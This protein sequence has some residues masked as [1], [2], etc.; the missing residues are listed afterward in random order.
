MFSPSRST[1]GPA[2][3]TR[4]RRRQRPLSS[5][6]ATQQPKVK[7]Q[8]VPLTEQTFADPEPQQQTQQPD[9]Q[10]GQ[11]QEQR[12]QQRRHHAHS[13]SIEVKADKSFGYDQRRNNNDAENLQQQQ[14]T[15]RRDL[16]V[17]A[18]K[19]KH[20]DRAANKGD[21]SLVLTSTDAYTVSKLPALP[22]RIR[23]D[24]S[25]DQHGQISS[26]FGYA[27][28]LT[29]T[30]AIVWP[31]TS[32]SPSPETFTFT[33]PPTSKP[34]DPLPVGCLVSPSAASTEPG[35]V[36]VMAATGRVVYWES[37]SSAAT[38]AFIKK[39]R[40]GVEYAV[41]GMTSGERVV[42][43]TS[44]ESAGFVLTFNT[45]RLAYLNVR[46]NHGR[47]AVSAQFL[48]SGLPTTTSFLGS[49]R[50]AFSHLS[51]R[52]DI[53]AVRA[54]RAAR[55]GEK[56]IVALGSKGR[57]QA[58]KIHRGGHNESLGEFDM[59]DEIVSALREADPKSHDFTGD[60]FEALDFTFVPKGLEAKY[61]ELSRLSQA[62]AIDDPALQHLVALVSLTRK[63]TSRYA[64]VEVILSPDGC[65][66]G[67]IRPI[68]SY[69]TPTTRS[70]V[71]QTM[72]P[73][74]YLP[75]PALVAF[76]IFDRA[77]VV[78]SVAVPPESPDSQL[79][80]DNHMVPSSFEDVV[81][82]R[83]DQ[84]HEILGSGFEETP[85]VSAD[86]RSRRQK[87]QNPAAVLLVRGAGVIRLVTSDIDKFAS[88]QAPSVTAKSKLE[89]AVFFGAKQD[90]PLIFGRRQEI[91]FPSEEVGRAALE[92][93]H[94]ILSSTTHYLSTLPAHLEDNLRARSQALSRLV[95]HLR[96]T[97]AKLNRATRWELLFNAEKMHVATLLWKRHET[98][99][100]S[101]STDDKKSLVG[102]IVE[103]IHDDQKHKPSARVGQVDPVRHWF[104]ND[105][106]RLDIF[107]AWAYEVIKVLY[108]DRLLDDAKVTVM[109]QEAMQIATCTH[110]AAMEFR[111]G[112]LLAYGLDG[113][114]LRNGVIVRG[115]EGLPEPWTAT[116]YVANN[117]RRLVDL[118]QQW[119]DSHF[120]SRGQEARTPTMPDP[121]ILEK[122][123]QDLPALTDG[124]LTSLLEHARY[125]RTATTAEER[126]MAHEFAKA[127]QLDRYERPRYLARI[128]HWEQAAAMAKKHG[129][130]DGLAAILL[131]HTDKLEADIAQPGATPA[132][133]RSATAKREAKKQQIEDD[134]AEFGEEFA[135]PLY[136][137]L[138]EKIGVGAVLEFEL[139][140]LGY[141]TKYLRSRPELAKISWINDVEVERDVGR[142]ADTLLGL[143]LSKEQQVW[144]RKVELSLGKLALLAE[145]EEQTADPATAATA[146]LLRIKPDEV[147]R[148]QSLARADKELTAI[149]IQEQLHGHVVSSTYGAVDDG[150]ALN[151]AMDTHST[152]IPRRQKA[153]YQIFEDGMRRLLAHEALDALT[154]IDLLT[155]VH[156]RP[157]DAPKNNGNHSNNGAG[158]I[159]GTVTGGLVADPF[160]LALCVAEACCKPQEL[161]EVKR[162]IWRRLLIRDDWPRINDTQLKDDT[163]VSLR[164]ADTT[165]FAAL[166][167]CI[168][169]EDPREPFRPMPPNEA[170]GAFTDALDRRFGDFD[171]DF[172]T[173]LRDAMKWED[174]MLTQYVER[175]RLS[176]WVRTTYEAAQ[177]EVQNGV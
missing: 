79:Q 165:L 66:V 75:R 56:N 98:F 91:R 116:H 108:R 126:R 70:D 19:T 154:L 25:A 40:S 117:A 33:L 137:F 157:D 143:A 162:L 54:D 158:G 151:F 44:A 23:S 124:M 153:L 39:D 68:T 152:N 169:F 4:S 94:E 51:L 118:A 46:D 21:G 26:S 16:S 123:Y 48:R 84:V 175:N 13:D 141:K 20:G 106:F 110:V 89:Q 10:P 128:G 11:P 12:Q 129:C 138:L 96:V 167:D 173:K 93:S 99:T 168:R 85:S 61:L 97:G 135:F 166:A 71:S 58:W 53:A 140:K 76:V 111:R 83:E 50:H 122:I 164:L 24:W 147:R 172:Q 36:V 103:F 101:R 133:K 114:E 1:G 161:R 163:E 74:L 47:P 60:S 127:Y 37:I 63:S 30:H 136:T 120:E 78:A 121:K 52:G 35:L 104:V 92:V 3:A 73:R 109:L 82:F 67:M 5:E 113:E 149:K 8:R 62:M 115:Y 9:P 27:L 41:P 77:A 86:T 148:E 64:L 139:D 170:K 28:T 131:D 87:A 43:I 119:N 105:I 90:N 107:V 42:D 134:L 72:R 32:T 14:S 145:A 88:E 59:R 31:Y 17:R 95:D 125:A 45:G 142:A 176:E 6:I 34:A 49:I 146:N 155:L 22:D 29:P 7:R 100:A 69:T 144:N 55:I 2:T 177:V 18:K 171:A 15:V 132:E 65:Q 160:W 102:S 150:A 156:L 81:D 174:K 57:F 159:D 112:N 38:F 130:L 80:V